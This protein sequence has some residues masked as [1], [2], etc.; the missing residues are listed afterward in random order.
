MKVTGKKINNMGEVMKPGQM[1]PA[2]KETMLKVKNMDLV[3]LLGQIK[4]LITDSLSKITL[5]GKV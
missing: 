1:V 2:M 3:N 4:V 5:M